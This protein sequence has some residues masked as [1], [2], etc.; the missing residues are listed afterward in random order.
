MRGPARR[1]RVRLLRLGR[2]LLGR[3]KLRRRCDRI[4]GAVI[5]LLLAAFI[6]ASAWSAGFAGHIYR[7]EHAAMARLRPAEAVLSRPAAAGSQMTAAA[8]TWLL[9]DGA[10]RSGMLTSITAPA[11]YGAPAGT[12]VKVWLDHSGQPAAPPAGWCD[13]IAIALLAGVVTIAG[14]ATVLILCYALCRVAL[15]RYRA[16]R[17]ESAWAAVGPRWTSRR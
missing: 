17:W 15:D 12:S 3:N 11:I 2:L 10:K 14:A 7:S 1:A 13:V 8:A 16:A 5:V 9:P 6:T 4:E